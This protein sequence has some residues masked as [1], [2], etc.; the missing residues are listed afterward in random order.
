M[1]K[2][3]FIRKPSNIDDVVSSEYNPKYA[4]PYQVVE[5]MVIANMLYDHFTN[6]LLQDNP[7]FAGGKGGQKNNVSQVIEIRSPNRKTL[8]VNPEGYEH[9]RYVA[10][11]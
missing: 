6:N 5:T 3:M 8:L 10:A 1:Q 2:A 4:E 11:I 7:W 9:A